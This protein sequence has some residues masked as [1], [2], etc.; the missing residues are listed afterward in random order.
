VSELVVAPELVKRFA[1]LSGDHN[2]LH[3]DPV[4]A[5]RLVFGEPVAHGVLLVLLVLD[6][7]LAEHDTPLVLERL[8]ATFEKPLPVNAGFTWQAQTTDGGGWRL[9]LR[10]GRA[11]LATLRCRFADDAG[12]EAGTLTAGEPLQPRAPDEP[13]AE[14]LPGVAG[15]LPLAFDS[16]LAERLFRHATRRLPDRQLAALLASTRV[17]GI[18]CPGL[19]SVFADLDLSFKPPG[20]AVQR[21]A[22]RVDAIDERFGRL[23]IA[24]SAPGVEGELGAFVRPRPQEQPAF[25]R[26]QELVESG[27]FAEQRALIVGGSRG[28]GEVVAKLL[29]AGGADVRLTFRLGGDEA[30]AVVDDIV[31]G[32]GRAAAV[33]LDVAAPPPEPTGLCGDAWRPSHLYFFATPPIS[34]AQRGIFSPKLLARFAAI[35]LDGFVHTVELIRAAGGPPP[36]VLWP[37]SVFVDELPA[38]MGEYAVAKAAGETL[39][40]FLERSWKGLEID[41]PRLPRLATD[42]TT[43]LYGTPAPDPAAVLLPVLR[44]MAGRAKPGRPRAARTDARDRRT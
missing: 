18:K 23:S 29:A 10:T 27:E 2:P 22:Y 26:L 11:R 32:G 43:A 5:R 36:R 17:V 14:A 41:R 7:W 25:G 38:D 24:V 4:A 34:G 6:R 20:G 3:V 30:T 15:T 39:C 44:R 28:L 1:L 40:R 35:Y 42:Q 9:R 37:S 33:E 31:R 21:L 16:R 12:P 13:K 8:Q 19:H